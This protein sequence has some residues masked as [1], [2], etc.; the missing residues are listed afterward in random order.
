MTLHG[1][2]EH[3][4]IEGTCC[5]TYVRYFQILLNHQVIRGKPSDSLW[6]RSLTFFFHF[7]MSCLLKMEPSWS[8]RYVEIHCTL[9]DLFTIYPPTCFT[10]KEK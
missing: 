1:Y 3:M 2:L 7:L 5:R 4:V 8:L 10:L 6:K 9:D